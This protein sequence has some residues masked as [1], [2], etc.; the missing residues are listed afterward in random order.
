MDDGEQTRVWLVERTYSDDKPN[1]IIRT[2]ATT[3]GEQSIRQERAVT[4]GGT[5][6]GRETTAAIDVDP[7]TLSPVDPDLQDRYA[8]EA[9]R[10]AEQHE[11]DDTI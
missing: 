7:E 3:N 8:A 9:A 4:G 10:M 5:A 6:T 11:P 1:L 2:Y